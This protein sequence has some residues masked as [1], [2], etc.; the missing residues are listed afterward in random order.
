M[1]RC[2]NGDLSSYVCGDLTLV[3]REDPESLLAFRELMGDFVVKVYSQIN[4]DETWDE[5]PMSDTR[6]H[7][8]EFDNGKMIM[9]SDAILS[10]CKIEE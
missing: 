3:Y 6:N 7:V 2:Q 8:I 10:P 5:H 9:M 4:E 1:K